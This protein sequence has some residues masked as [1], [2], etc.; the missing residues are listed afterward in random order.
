MLIENLPANV[1]TLLIQ[2]LDRLNK[3]PTYTDLAEIDWDNL[4]QGYAFWYK[5]SQGIFQDVPE[6]AAA[7]PILKVGSSTP[8]RAKPLQ[9]KSAHLI[10]KIKS[11]I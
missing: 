8:F 7:D 10:E 9:A 11:S 2:E 3:I 4:S 1:K 6:L 5:I